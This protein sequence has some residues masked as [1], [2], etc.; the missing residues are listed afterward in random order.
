M[1]SDFPIDIPN[2][3]LPVLIVISAGLVLS[4]LLL[5]WVA[6]RVKRVAL[7]AGA[8][9][10]EALR[11]TPLAVVLLLDALDLSLDIF[12]APLSWA[13]LGRLGLAPLRAVSIIEGLIP[14]TQ[15]LPTMTLAWIIVRLIGRRT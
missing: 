10:I 14:G 15:L 7:P 9:F 8:G 5:I 6:W 11:A 13:I 3:V 12:S 4:L 2:W 1:P